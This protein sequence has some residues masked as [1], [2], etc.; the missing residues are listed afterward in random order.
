[1]KFG[2][3]NFRFIGRYEA[4]ENQWPETNLISVPK[5]KKKRKNEDKKQKQGS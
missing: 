2:E 1:M 4:N 3:H 5:E